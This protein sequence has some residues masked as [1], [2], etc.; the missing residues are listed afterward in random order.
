[1]SDINNTDAPAVSPF[2]QEKY[3]KDSQKNWNLFYKRNK[4]NFFK[5]RHWT[6]RE[7]EVL[8]QK[9][10]YVLFEMG[11][12][13]GNFLLPLLES[14]PNA[15]FIGCDVSSKAIE[16]LSSHPVYIENKSRCT[17]FVADISS[18][19][20]T[21]P[22]E[23]MPPFFTGLEVQRKAGVDIV[24]L[25]FV[26]S[27]FHPKHHEQVVRNAWWVLKSGGRLLFRDYARSDH[28]QS[29]F[30]NDRKLQT[31]LY[32]RQDGTLAFFFT[33]EYIEDLFQRVGFQKLE[34][35]CV[36][37]KTVNHKDSLDVD[38]VFVQS[39]WEKP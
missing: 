37:R 35:Q 31:D 11:C 22:N 29:R 6:T 19:P 33:L 16:L 8:L 15:T 14:C 23:P 36:H 5:D 24:S 20:L 28:A 30:G 25:I 17:V 27:A 2:W 18:S 10:S 9:D 38:R 7:F 34:N 39:Q 4:D 32:V 12:G 21:P 1:M 13:V 26:L 3:V